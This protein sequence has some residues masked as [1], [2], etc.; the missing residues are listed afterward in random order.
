MSDQRCW[1]TLLYLNTERPN[2]IQESRFKLVTFFLRDMS[3]I[4]GYEDKDVN[5]KS[6]FL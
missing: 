4:E 5:R 2:N 6:R 3:N 1:K